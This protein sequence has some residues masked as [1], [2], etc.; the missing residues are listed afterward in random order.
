MSS[1]LLL[2]LLAHAPAQ[3]TH[4]FDDSYW[5]RDPGRA[6]CVSAYG[7][8]KCG[9]GCVAAYGRITCAERPGQSCLADNGYVRCGYGCVAAYGQVR[10]AERRGQACLAEY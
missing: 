3:L 9:Y 2:L 10:C 6:Q 5:G 4:D 8:T 1:L 7:Q